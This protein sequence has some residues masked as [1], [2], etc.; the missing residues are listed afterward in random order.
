MNFI[1]NMNPASALLFGMAVIVFAKEWRIAKMEISKN[2][3]K[4]YIN[5][6]GSSTA[7]FLLVCAWGAFGMMS[8]PLSHIPQWWYSQTGHGA[9][10]WHW[11]S[12]AQF[13]RWGS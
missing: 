9:S 1:E 3:I 5:M 13:P 8:L 6:W 2:T 11:P 4:A 12:P 7:I 10:L